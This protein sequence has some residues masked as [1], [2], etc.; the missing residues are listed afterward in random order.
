VNLLIKNAIGD[1]AEEK[2]RVKVIAMDTLRS[3]LAEM[4]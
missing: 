3:K 2:R 1:N 4:I